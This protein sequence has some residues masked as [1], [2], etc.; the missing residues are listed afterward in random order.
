MQ[1]E[2]P[3]EEAPAQSSQTPNGLSDEELEQRNLPPLRGPWSRVQRQAPTLSPRDQAEMQLHAIESGYSAP[4][5]A[6]RA[7]STIAPAPSAT[8]TFPLLEAPV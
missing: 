1:Q 4:G 6:V 7:L 2:Q 5:W 8:I 3:G